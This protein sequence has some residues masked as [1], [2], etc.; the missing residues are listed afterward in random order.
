[1][2]AV[3]ERENVE[4]ISR[5]GSRGGLLPFNSRFFVEEGNDKAN[6]SEYDREYPGVM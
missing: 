1:M 3:W 5:P 6:S 4:N 2:L